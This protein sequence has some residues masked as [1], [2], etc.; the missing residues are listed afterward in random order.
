MRV[1]KGAWGDK[2]NPLT[3]TF[4]NCELGFD[5]PVSAMMLGAH[6]ESI[7]VNGLKVSAPEDIHLLSLWN[8]ET[9][10]PKMKIENVRGVEPSVK[11]AQTPWGVTGI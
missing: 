10:A 8:A 1:Y 9:L 4:K 11:N 7:N 2:A 3:I 6:I 5:K